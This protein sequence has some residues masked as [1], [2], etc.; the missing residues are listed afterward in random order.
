MPRTVTIGGVR[1]NVIRET[2]EIWTERLPSGQLVHH[3]GKIIDTPFEGKWLDKP[4]PC[5]VC[6]QPCR[7][8]NGPRGRVFHD[9]CEGWTRVLPDDVEAQIVFAAAVAL[10]G[11]F[12]TPVTPGKEARRAA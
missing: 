6:K 5:S 3:L 11:S 1:R 9:T 7:T 2:S 4:K 8:A 10:G 12:L